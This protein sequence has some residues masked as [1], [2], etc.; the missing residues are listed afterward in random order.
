MS[1]H[2]AATHLGPDARLVTIT[3]IGDTEAALPDMDE[4]ALMADSIQSGTTARQ[5]AKVSVPIP[6]RYSNRNGQKLENSELLDLV[7][8]WLDGSDGQARF[9]IQGGNRYISSYLSGEGIDAFD[10]KLSSISKAPLKHHLRTI[11]G[12][13]TSALAE[14]VSQPTLLDQY[15]SGTVASPFS[16]VTR[17]EDLATELAT[18]VRLMQ[19]DGISI[20]YRNELQR[21]LKDTEFA[22]RLSSSEELHFIDDLF[23][24]GRTIYALGVLV[25]LF[26]ADPSQIRLTAIGCDPKSKQLSTPY[27]HV[28]RDDVLYPFENSVRTEQGYWQDTGERYEF[29]DMGAYLEYRH[30]GLRTSPEQAVDAYETFRHD[31]IKWTETVL[32]EGLDETLVFPLAWLLLYHE[33][34]GLAIDTDKLVDQKGYKIGASAPFVALLDRFVSQEETVEVRLHFKQQIRRQLAQLQV[35]AQETPSDYRRLVQSYVEQKGEIDYGYLS[36]IFSK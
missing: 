19:H 32:E 24:R 4:T 1:S 20:P 13:D 12:N 3:P 8:T 18:A 17:D 31:T 15:A 29:T 10:I 14:A 25:V 7:D 16:P 9:V 35:S 27:H 33:A 6:G 28:L 30:Q 36:Q 5:F 2:E 23:Y 22:Q 21:A 11:V 26:G 34:H